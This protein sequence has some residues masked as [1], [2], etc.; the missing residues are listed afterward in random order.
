MNGIGTLA[1]VLT[2]AFLGCQA[3]I[4]KDDRLLPRRLAEL[5]TKYNGNYSVVFNSQHQPISVDLTG[6]YFM[7]VVGSND[8]LVFRGDSG[9]RCNSEVTNEH[10]SAVAGMASLKELSL[11]GAD[12][13]KADFGKLRLSNVEILR[14]AGTK[15]TTEQI[16]VLGGCKSLKELDLRDVAMSPDAW[17]ALSELPRLEK[18]IVLGKELETASSDILRGFKALTIIEVHQGLDDF[19][20]KDLQNAN[21]QPISTSTVPAK[22]GVI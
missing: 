19:E 3:Q 11:C 7:P 4:V 18:L 6:F 16:M 10:F 14:M 5:Q 8:W 12:I 9:L 1:A 21:G 20:L 15:P 2:L 13:K 22:G 17:L